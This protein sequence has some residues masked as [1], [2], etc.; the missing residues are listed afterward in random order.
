L[1][2]R[3]SLGMVLGVIISRRAAARWGTQ[4]E[5]SRT[6]RRLL[7]AHLELVPVGVRE[8]EDGAPLFLLDRPRDLDAVLAE[9]G[10]LFLGV[11]RGEEASRVPFLRAGVRA[12]GEADVGP[13][14]PDRDPMRPRRHDAKAQVVVPSARRLCLRRH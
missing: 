11:F 6:T 2:I 1:S 13:S 14:R 4:R 5:S 8:P 12:E 10:L 7:L 9:P 3:E